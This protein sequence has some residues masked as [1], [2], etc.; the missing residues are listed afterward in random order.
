MHELD[1]A[2]TYNHVTFNTNV[3]NFVAGAVWQW[4]KLPRYN[5]HTKALEVC[6]SG[7]DGLVPWAKAPVTLK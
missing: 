7:N 5:G 3:V 6:A 2:L 4:V 1:A